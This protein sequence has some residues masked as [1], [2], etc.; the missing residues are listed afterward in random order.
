MREKIKHMD[1]FIKDS[2]HELNTPISVLMTSVSMLKKGKKPDKMM[3][4]ISSSSKQISQIYNDIHFSAFDSIHE[5]VEEEF[6]LK[7]LISDSVEYFNDIS[8][9]KNITIESELDEC[10]ILMDRTKTQKI[11]NNLIS[12]S[13]K[14]SHP[15]TTVIVSLKACNFSVQDFGIGISEKDQ[16]EV[17][18]RYKRTNSASNVEGGFGIGLDIVKRISSDYNLDIGLISKIDEGSTFSINFKNVII[19]D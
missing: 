6:S 7:D 15:N 12:N 18:K 9:T 4:Y 1:N 5:S 14:Y 11:V 8:I 13:I 10:T 2:A 3:K 19:K 16:L 17:F